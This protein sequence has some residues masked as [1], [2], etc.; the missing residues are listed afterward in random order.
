MGEQKIWPFARLQ[1]SLGGAAE[2][3]LLRACMTIGAGK[4]DPNPKR[5]GPGQNGRLSLALQRRG[6]L[7]SHPMPGQPRDKTGRIGGGTI[8]APGAVRSL[9]DHNTPSVLKQAQSGAHGACSFDAAIPCD[10]RDIFKSLC[11]VAC[12]ENAEAGA[13]HDALKGARQRSLAACGVGPENKEVC[14]WGLTQ[15][16]AF[17]IKRNPLDGDAFGQSG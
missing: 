7:S 11:A 17:R 3:E 4:Q 9:Q 16:S 6:D 8:F 15:Q 2:Q 1:E 14:Q 12:D 5:G 10:R 13:H